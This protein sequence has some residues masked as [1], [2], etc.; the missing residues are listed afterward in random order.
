MANLEKI[1]RILQ[2]QSRYEVLMHQNA[3]AICGIT[4]DGYFFE[5]NE[6]YVNLLGYAPN[7]L[8]GIHFQKVVFPEDVT[9]HI[10][11]LKQPRLSREARTAALR[12]RHR[13]GTPVYAHVNVIPIVVD[14]ACIGVYCVVKDVHDSADLRMA[15]DAV[16]ASILSAQHVANVGSFVW[17]VH[18]G[19]MTGSQELQRIL[20]MT[21]DRE[22]M[23]VASILELVEEEERP[24]VEAAFQDALQTDGLDVEFWIHKADD[25]RRRLF[26][27]MAQT[28]RDSSDDVVYLVGSIHDMTEQ[29]ETENYLRRSQNLS[30]AGQLAAGVAHEIRNPLTAVKGFLQL[31]PTL[32]EPD[33][34][35]S[36]M[37]DELSR[38]EQIVNEL[39]MLAKPQPI[40]FQRED[41]GRRL[42]E[43][44]QLL[45]AQAILN[46]VVVD[47][48]VVDGVPPVEC[49]L[50]QLKQVFINVLKNGMEAMPSGG[51][52]DVLLDVQRTGF[53]SI[54]IRDFGQGMTA[55]QL[56]KLGEPFFTTKERGTGL[57]WMISEKIIQNHRGTIDVKSQLG[58]GTSVTIFLPVT[59]TQKNAVT[60][61]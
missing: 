37:L 17:Q 39:L 30:V 31:M 42:S 9:L 8:L 59:Q 56:E 4:T 46:N 21:L 15:L 18:S 36:L 54:H 61:E 33:R 29:R 24:G 48:Q 57:G 27:A 25:H 35:I 6:S 14:E 40:H 10:R 22:D 50:N 55:F 7:E 51:R 58:Q 13:G 19:K 12:L 26:H 47:L 45:G 53:V 60:T 3:D 43:V 2:E 34:A 5:V 38:I 1:Q 41:L 44:L 28:V 11:S 23:H 52:I 49:E 20:G 32:A 16:H